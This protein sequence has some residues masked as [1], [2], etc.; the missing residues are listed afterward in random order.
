MAPA[1]Q[2]ATGRDGRPTSR[3]FVDALMFRRDRVLR[4]FFEAISPLD[5]FTVEDGSLCGTDLSARHKLVREGDIEL[6]NDQGAVVDVRPIGPDARGCVK[7][8]R[9]DY[10]VA[11][12]RI[13]RGTET[14][15]TVDVH[16]RDRARVVGVVRV[17]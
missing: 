14:H 1:P 4:T 7:L 5:E 9:H 15:P 8:P 3:Y 10:T 13:R 11:R 16:V 6:V 17:Q 12:V 2:I